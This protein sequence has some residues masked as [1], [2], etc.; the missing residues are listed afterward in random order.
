ME[1]P[2]I[3]TGR[4]GQPGYEIAVED[5]G[6][7]FEEIYLDRIFREFQRLHG[8]GDYEGT[9]MGLAI[10]REIVERHHGWVTARSARVEGPPSW[11]PFPPIGGTSMAKTPVRILLI[12]DDEDDYFLAHDLLSDIPD[13]DFELDWLADP[14]VALEAMCSQEHDMLLIDYQ[15][16]RVDG[17]SLLRAAIRRGCTA[18]MILLTGQGE[19][20]IDLGA[21][22]AGA[23]DFLEKGKLDAALLE[24]TIRYALQGKRHAEELERRVHE[25]TMELAMAN[26]ALQ[27]EVAERAR[28]EQALRETD[29]RKDEFLS[30]LA[31]ELRNPLVPIRNALEIMRLSGNNPAVVESCRAMLERQIKQMV[32]LIDDLLDMARMSR[33]TIQ[34]KKERVELSRIVAA[35]VESCRPLIDAAGHSLNVDLPA[36]PVILNADPTRLTQAL[37]NLLNN[38]AKYTEPGGFIRL[39]AVVDDAQVVLRVQDTGLGISPASLATIFDM[40]S[41]INRPQEGSQ[42]GLGLGLSLVK[43]LVNL[44]GGSVEAHSGGP[45][46]GSEF[47]IRLPLQ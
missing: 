43:T 39:T 24:R 18:P 27:A 9:G 28:A 31:H 38:A 14:D 3:I 6:I 1:D 15:L 4:P 41:H 47:I 20:A 7:G 2:D 35:A 44:H 8:R 36:E 16:G 40:L 19:R 46:Q 26:Q 10:C 33:G 11:S 23:V 22:Q 37:L 29:R 42:S 5:N 45:G 30:T 17:L 32:R 34:L 13:S 25:R 12:D 21:M